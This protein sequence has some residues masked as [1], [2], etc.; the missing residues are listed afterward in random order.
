MMAVI[1]LA[2]ALVGAGGLCLFIDQAYADDEPDYVAHS[3]KIKFI[4]TATD[5]QHVKWDF[6]DGTILD[7]RDVDEPGYADLLM[8]HGGNVWAPEHQYA[9]GINTDYVVTQTVYNPYNGGSED[10]LTQ[11]IRIVGP[12]VITIDGTTMSP[13]TVPY[14]DFQP[15]SATKPADPLRDGYT[16]VGYYSDEARTVEYDWS[17][18]VAEDLTLYAKWTPVAGPAPGGD[19]D[20]E[21]PGQDD[22]DGTP[23]ISNLT[24]ALGILAAISIVGAAYSRRPAIVMVAIV[25]IAL[26]AAEYLGHLDFIGGWFNE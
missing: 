2:I 14:V 19:G 25:L 13:I 16:F 3:Y 23:A 11:V 9:D 4:S 1:G 12:P 6:G 20:D 17:T 10:S 7:S 15:S 22:V 8:A 5:A 21:E 26:T 18:P 24:I